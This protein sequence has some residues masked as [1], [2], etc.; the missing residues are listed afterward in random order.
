MASIEVMG[1]PKVITP[2]ALDAKFKIVAL[3]QSSTPLSESIKRQ[4]LIQLFPVLVQLGVDPT[5]IKEEVI[6]LYDFPKSFLEATPQVEA[7]SGAPRGGTEA[8]VEDP[9]G[10]LPSDELARILTDRGGRV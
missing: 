1:L 9:S 2:E 5:K 4:N 3:D 6:R 7:P 10:E 8:P